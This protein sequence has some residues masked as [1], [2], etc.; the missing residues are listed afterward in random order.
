MVTSWSSISR[1]SSNCTRFATRLRWVS[2][3]PF[4][5]PVVPLEYGSAATASGS[6]ATGASGGPSSSAP[7]GTTVSGAP[8]GT[9]P[10]TTMRRT[11]LSA[12]AARAVS[13][14]GATVTRIW[15]PASP[16]WNAVSSGP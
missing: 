8:S 12:A 9:S 14:N 3:T 10:I 13:R 7:K 1:M 4:G 16:S 6:T 15:A 2:I 11:S 5:R